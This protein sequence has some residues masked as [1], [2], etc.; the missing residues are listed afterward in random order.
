MPELTGTHMNFEKRKY[1]NTLAG[2]FGC[3]PLYLDEPNQ[4]KPNIRKLAEQPWH[5]TKSQLWK[6][7]T[8]TLCDVF[9]IEA[10]AKAKML[11][12]QQEEYSE[13]LNFNTD[14][15][16]TKCLDDFYTVFMQ[17][18]NVIRDYPE[19][20]FQQLYNELQWKEERTK[21]II[22]NTRKAFHAKGRFFIHQYREPQ[23]IDSHLLMTFTGHTR[24]VSSCAFSPDGK[25]IVSGS[26]DKTLIIWDV[27]YG[28]IIKTLKGHTN[29][30]TCCTFSLMAGGLYQ[31]AKI[32]N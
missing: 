16:N 26:W 32:S 20:T 21:S 28:R 7:V 1:T 19:L 17:Q 15:E 13:V 4:T 3:K 27:E 18:K 29:W 23:I 11:D 25:R 30:V 6:E 31:E 8:E 9:F 24:G 5:Q 12:L 10:R 2:Y 22:E 14:P